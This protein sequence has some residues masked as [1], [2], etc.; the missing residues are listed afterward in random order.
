MRLA[1]V[2]S[3]LDCAYRLDFVVEGRVLVELKAVG[4]LT[5]VHVA[6]VVTYL[7]LSRLEVALLINFNVRALKD[8]IRRLTGQGRTTPS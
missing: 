8:G 1:D 4:A 3:E 2:C 6:Q 7:R 5:P